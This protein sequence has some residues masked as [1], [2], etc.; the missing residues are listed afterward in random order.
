MFS[1]AKKAP[2]INITTVHIS[3]ILSGQTPFPHPNTATPQELDSDQ[4]LVMEEE[5]V[6]SPA[7]LQSASK[8]AAA[9]GTT[10]TNLSSQELHVDYSIREKWSSCELRFVAVVPSAAAGLLAD[11]K[12]TRLN[13]S[14]PS[15]SRMPSSA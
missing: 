13:S 14:H 12:S 6:L 4:T 9:L 8:P 7:P 11:R 5:M 2:A 15:I 1:Q 3:N 10:A